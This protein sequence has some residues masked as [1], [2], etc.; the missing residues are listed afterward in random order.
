MPLKLQ[1]YDGLEILLLL[2][3]DPR[4]NKGRENWNI[5]LKSLLLQA[6]IHHRAGIVITVY[7]C[8]Y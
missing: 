5:V 4:K 2:L 6:V 8:V 3:F 7:Y 1:P